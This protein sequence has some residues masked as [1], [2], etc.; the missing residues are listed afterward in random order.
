MTF[1]P[2]G[3]PA[4]WMERSV[5]ARSSHVKCSDLRGSVKYPRFGWG[6]LL[7]DWL[8]KAPLRP[9]RTVPV[10][11]RV[12]VQSFAHWDTV[13]NGRSSTGDGTYHVSVGTSS[14]NL[15]LTVPVRWWA[16][17]SGSRAA[18]SPGR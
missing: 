6:A 13:A 18:I 9:G 5:N 4:L 10:T 11:L 16:D 3:V 14:D 15:P 12:T 7:L 17:T 1:Q 8:T 2:R